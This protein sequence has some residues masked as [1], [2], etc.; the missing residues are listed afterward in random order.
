MGYLFTKGSIGGWGDSISHGSFP[1]SF[2]DYIKIWIDNTNGRLSQ[3]FISALMFQ[4]ARSILNSPVDYPWWLIRGLSF[5]CLSASCIFFISSFIEY[6]D[7][8]RLLFKYIFIIM[9]IIWLFN[10]R[11]YESFAWFSPSIFAGYAFSLY[12]YTY[13]FRC[14]VIAEKSKI[15]R[16]KTYLIITAVSFIFSLL[17]EPYIFIIPLTTIMIAY[18][19]F[20]FLNIHKKLIF[21]FSA[22]IIG[23]LSGLIFLVNSTG[24]KVR[25]TSLNIGINSIFD[26]FFYSIYSGYRFIIDYDFTNNLIIKIV[27]ILIHLFLFIYLFKKSF[28]ISY[29][30]KFNIIISFKNKEF[31]FLFISLIIYHSFYVTLVI[32]NYYPTYLAILP[33]FFLS[34]IYSSLISIYI[35]KTKK[36]K[37]FK[38][39]TAIII[40]LLTVQ[41]IRHSIENFRTEKDVHNNDQRRIAIYK[42]ITDQY[43]QGF[44]KFA[45]IN[46]PLASV[47]NNYSMDPPWGY[48]AWFEWLDI[49]DIS[50][51]LEQNYDFPKNW[52]DGTYKIID[53]K[54]DL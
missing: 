20:Y 10:S 25:N 40:T 37:A 48:S 30:K 33:A 5:Y 46:C 24:Q 1:G 28:S 23:S 18:F 35:I 21:L 42:I 13:F 26:S 7:Q 43:N 44:L 11:T 29:F 9:I 34:F 50:I 3:A 41:L 39:I 17:L 19:R 36:V 38:I 49:N 16:L 27:V 31:I 32:S 8:K 22:T 14:L 52:N 54:K 47:K 53:C 15:F 12:I 51:Y 6:T 2:F 45:I 4:P